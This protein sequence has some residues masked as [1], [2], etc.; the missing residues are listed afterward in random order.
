MYIRDNNAPGAEDLVGYFDQTY[1]TGIFNLTVIQR[2]GIDGP[3]NVRMRRVPPCYPHDMWNV[4]Q[5]TLDGV[6]E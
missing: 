4:Y 3:A 6:Q 2:D 1:V 5:A